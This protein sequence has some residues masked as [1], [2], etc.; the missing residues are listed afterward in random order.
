MPEGME[1]EGGRP[2]GPR[3]FNGIMKATV[4]IATSLDGFIAR[5]DGDIDWLP[6]IGGPGGEDYGYSAF[7]RTVDV[8][9]MGSGSYEKVLT[10]G[11]WPYP[12]PVVVLSSR[13]LDPPPAGT[14]SIEMMSG[15]P[16]EV[17]AR[18]SARGLK[19]AYVDGGRTIQRFLDEGLIQR[20]IIT[21]I[22][23][24][25]GVGLPL[26]GPLRHDIPLKHVETRSYAN[27]LVQSEYMIPPGT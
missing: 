16:R 13:Q 26:F 6:P 11:A 10:F 8:I 9:I 3:D 5:P 25:I 22:P 20:L 7:M 4:Y 23:V 19:H 24:L 27:G 12:K 21:R 14:A 17:I 18:L 15:S 2:D 1:P